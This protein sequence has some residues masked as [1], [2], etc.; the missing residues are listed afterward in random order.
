VTATKATIATVG[1]LYGLG[2]G[3]GD[4]ELIT[5]KARRILEAAPVIAYPA[6]EHGA[7]VARL[8]ADSHV[9]AGRAEIAI[10]MAMTP[11]NF[12]A[13]DVYDRAASEIGGHLSHGRDVAVLCEGDP[14]LYGSFMYL[15]ARIAETFPVVVVPGVS[16]LGA[17]TA[18]AGQPLVSRNQVL[19]VV[20]APL[21]EDELAR[22]LA[23]VEAA[24]IMKVG[25]HLAKVKRVLGRLGL[26]AGARYVAR[27][28]M[29]DERVCAL[30]EVADDQAPY[31]SMILVR[32]E[33]AAE[34]SIPADDLPAR[35]AIVALSAGGLA[36]A[37]RLK[38]H[39]PAAEA[40]GLA[41]RADG[42]DATFTDVG[43]HL[44]ALFADG[45]PIV[46]VCAAGI[47]VRAVAPLLADKRAEPPVV[48]VAEDASAV[49]PL[50]G[51]HHGGNRIARAL[52]DALGVAA[53]VTTAGDLRLGLALDEPPAGWR[54]ANPAAAKAIMGALLAGAPV[55]LELDAGDGGWLTASG[56]AFAA[57]A[58]LCV[59]VTDRAVAAP[60]EDLVLHPPVLALGVGC[61]RGADAVELIALADTALAGAGLAAG[62]VACV[63]SI[64]V[65]MDEDAVLA[66]ADRLGAPARF[67][68]AADLE[69]ETPRL[70]H[71][72][73]IVFRAVGCHGVA[74]A[75]ALV[76]AGAGGSLVVEK[77]AA[78]RCTVAIARAAQPFDAAGVGRGRGSLAIVGIGPGQ[79]AW[80]TPE[81]TAALL[82][83]D[84]V[85]GYRLYLDLV[86]DLVAGKRLHVSELTEEE[87]RVRLAL[88]LAGAGNRVALIGSGDAGIYGLASL[89]FELMAR[90]ADVGWNRVAVTVAPGVS[91]L[92][93]AAA[94]VGAPLGHDFCAISLSDLLTPWAEIERRLAAAAAGDFVVALYN[95]VSKRRRHQ[96]ARARDILLGARPSQTPVALARNLGRADESVRI[97]SL[98][99]LSPEMADMLT[100][101]LV[102]S[103]RTR[104]VETGGRRWLYTPRGYGDRHAAAPAAGSFS[105]F[106]APAGRA[107]SGKE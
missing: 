101:V 75:A 3:P 14:F 103:S 33:D 21:P 5:L 98:A 30:A 48:A 6:P 44:R 78:G 86:A 88:D 32:R 60:G 89:V 87:V 59:R 105:E 23:G 13:A 10:R 70:A 81:A 19:T 34:T 18:V 9:P 52:A 41:G 45:R 94:R 82:A 72:S 56:I 74:E 40:H 107:V 4:P 62:A 79:A 96:L 39:L 25:R 68:T 46:G 61:E 104:T 27:A 93:A 35:A 66:V 42:G 106:A 22:R 38:A 8:I 102:G 83:A 95:P 99:E 90:Q 12:P 69:K 26:A 24:A 55:A 11:G 65:K 20:P 63:A 7:S 73:D 100:L 71:P 64:D 2:V 31:F 77:R 50:L 80:R 97:V 54:V 92:Q 67:F 17:C 84:H 85:V 29:A 16:S 36:L 58:D 1:T 53:A 49:V 28:G 57:R 76:A 91:A 37:R 47:L 15:Y 51:G 43:D